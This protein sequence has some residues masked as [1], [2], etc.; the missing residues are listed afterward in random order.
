[1]QMDH[2]Y[3]KTAKF[4]FYE[5][6]NDFLP[7][8]KKGNSFSYHFNGAPRIRDVMKAAGVP[9]ADVDLVLVNGISAGLDSRLQHNDRISV[10][11]V[12]ESLDISPLVRLRK[13]PLRKSTFILD[14]HLGR[15]AKLLRMLGFDSLYRNNFEDS[16][17]INISLKEKRIILTRDK[18]LLKRK[19]VTH[20]YWIKS[21]KP[22]RQIQEVV[23]RFDLLSQIRPF[24]RCMVCNGIINKIDKTA[25]IHNLPAAAA[26]YYKEFYTCL[27]CGRIYWKGSHYNK[28]LAHINEL[29]NS[30]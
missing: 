11:P 19:A 12:F 21:T 10:Y 4:R 5:E 20:G 6:L 23:K 29:R 7:F 1:M 16:E 26:L 9:H 27:T 28:M 18:G 24:H 14:V 17:I 2:E 3:P 8:D 30:Q 25:G 13:R 15:L 22:R